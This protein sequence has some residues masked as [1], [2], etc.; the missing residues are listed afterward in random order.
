[1]NL[2][3]LLV[4]IKREYLTRVKSKGFVIA[5]V[6]TPLLMASLIILPA[7][8]MGR[9][10]PTDYRGVVLDQTGDV[11]LYERARKLLTAENASQDR[12]QVRREA[13]SEIQPETRLQELNREIGE[14]MLDFFVVIPALVLDEGR[15][16]YH[17][18]S[19]GNL[20]AETRVE[21]AFNTA[22]IEQRMARSGLEVEQVGRLSRKTILEKFNVR[23]EGE[24]WRKVIMAFSLMGILCL[25]VLAY[26]GHTMSAVIE[27]KQSRIIE[28]L[29]S[30]VEPFSLMLGKLIGVG[31]VG[32]TQYAVWAVCAV[33]LSGLTISYLLR[34]LRV[35]CGVNQI[36]FW[37]QQFRC[38]HFSVLLRCFFGLPFSSLLDGRSHFQSC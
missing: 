37:Q 11:G 20:I 5:T 12:F 10:S 22:V 7:L 6:I 34:L 18:K 32:L 35:S 27:E 24:E 28:V 25:T 23:G 16:T 2:D 21:N 14:G 36:A 3:K 31:L 1:M 17:A 26:G 9:G 30:S 15:I 38:F 19:I 13:L 4:I 33:F 8:L 29:L